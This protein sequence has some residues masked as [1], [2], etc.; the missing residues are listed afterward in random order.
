MENDNTGPHYCGNI[1]VRRSKRRSFINKVAFEG[2]FG[3]LSKTEFK[4]YRSSS[5]WVSKTKFIFDIETRCFIC[6]IFPQT[7]LRSLSL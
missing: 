7:F 1:L 4:Y 5:D 2:V 3:V 6:N